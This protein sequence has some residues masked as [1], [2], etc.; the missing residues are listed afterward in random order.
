MTNQSSND[1]TTARKIWGLLTSAERHSAVILLGLIFIGT[2]V[3]T[4]GVGLVIPA[5]VLLTQRDFASHYPALQPALHVL[6]N[7]GQ[8]SLVVGGML[9]LVGVYLVKAIFL[10]ILAR[11]QA[12]FVFGVQAQLSQ[13]LF[14]V[15]LR[16]PYTFHLQR[17]SAQLIRNVNTDVSMFAIN[18]IQAGMTLLSECLVLLGLG[19]LL[20]V[21]EPLGTLI[22]VS[23]LGTAAWGFNR[24]TQRTHCALGRGAPASRRLA[25]PAPAA[26]SGQRQGCEAARKGRRLSG[27]ISHAHG[28]ERPRRAVGDHPATTAAPMA[29]TACRHRV[30]RTGGQHGGAGP[31]P[32]NR[33]AHAG[34]VCRCRLS[35]DAFGQPR[36][37]CDAV[38]ALRFAGNRYPAARNSIS[39]PPK[40]SAPAPR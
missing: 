16:Q 37:Q 35:P 15:Y 25:P 4:L 39:P 28:P 20:L 22:V 30:R 17:N 12:R 11:Q 21:V 40:Q 31:R 36:N 38:A 10:A 23:V 2:V 32:G 6:G 14:M 1:L 26:G 33:T 34:S 9:M 29:G 24:L 13:R 19:T 5:I 3:E 18:G 7:P 8:Q 27:A